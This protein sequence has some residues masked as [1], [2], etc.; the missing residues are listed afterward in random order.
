M[1]PAAAVSLAWGIHGFITMTGPTGSSA[2]LQGSNAYTHHGKQREMLRT[3]QKHCTYLGD[4]QYLAATTFLGPLLGISQPAACQ[5]RKTFARQTGA[6][7]A[8]RVITL[9]L[10][11]VKAEVKRLRWRADAGAKPYTRVQGAPQGANF[12]SNAARTVTVNPKV[13]EGEQ[14]L[15]PESMQ[16]LGGQVL[17]DAHRPQ[18]DVSVCPACARP[19]ALVHDARTSD[20]R[21][22]D[23]FWTCRQCRQLDPLSGRTHLMWRSVRQWLWKHSHAASVALSALRDSVYVAVRRVSSVDRSAMLERFGYDGSTLSRWLHG[24]DTDTLRT[25][26]LAADALPDNVAWMRSH[27]P[28]FFMSDSDRIALALARARGTS[29]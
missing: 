2:V 20:G 29:P 15:G 3:I 27:C 18:T 10:T 1:N 26:Q 8:G 16:G 23:P 19:G 12:L 4:C 5:R 21:T 9:P 13:R 24:C 28:Q 25:M 22:I 6:V 7:I 17:T 14:A 11:M